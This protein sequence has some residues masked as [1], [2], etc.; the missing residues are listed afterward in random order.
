M[1]DTER[2]SR[3]AELTA[4]SR[5]KLVLAGDAAQL[6]PI[7]AGGLFEQLRGSGPQRRAD[8][9]P[10]RQPRLGAPRPGSRS[11]TANPVR[12][13]PSTRPTIASTS[14]TPAPQAAEA[15]VADW[16]ETR[17]SLP[18]G[19]A[20]M[21]TDASNAERDQ[22]NAM[23]QERR[24]A[25][26]RARLTPGRAARQ[27]LRPARRRRGDLL[28]PVPH[29]PARGGSRTGSPAPSST[30]TATRTGS[31]SRPTSASRA[32]WRSTPREFSDLN[33]GYAVHV[34]KA[35]GITAEASGILTGGWQTDREHAYVALSRARE[36]TQVYVSRED[37]GEA[38][39]GRRRDRTARRA[40]APQRRAGG[41][42][43]QGG[44]RARRGASGADRARDRAR[45][46]S[47][48]RVRDRVATL[49]ARLRSP[50]FRVV[51]SAWAVP[52]ALPVWTTSGRMSRPRLAPMPLHLFAGLRVRDFQAARPWYERLLG[53]PTFFSHATVDACRGS[54]GLRRGARG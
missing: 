2:L 19:K 39:D 21:I 48:S 20:V 43:R 12:R 22:I 15:M 33:L 54:V 50:A 18:A 46:G 23:A 13:S 3:L 38:G 25:G 9:G 10:P 8:R 32:R 1:A 34:Y 24:A 16:D 36:Q 47:R 27:A 41:E 37:L 28:R 42:H 40:D 31:R 6:G 5:S 51:A 29:P 14:T 17:R 45:P 4:D 52:L 7:G 30:P 11:E 35:Q 49:F 53:E 26:G 44:R